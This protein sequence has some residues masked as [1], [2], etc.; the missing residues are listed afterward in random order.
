MN[1]LTFFCVGAGMSGLFFTIKNIYKKDWA[2]AKLMGAWT[3]LN[4]IGLVICLFS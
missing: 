3:L 1:F 4:L 2:G